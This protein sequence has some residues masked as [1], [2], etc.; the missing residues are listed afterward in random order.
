MSGNRE[1]L[2]FLITRYE[3]EP[4][5][6]RATGLDGWTQF[7]GTMAS[8]RWHARSELGDLEPRLLKIVLEELR[9]D[10]SDHQGRNNSIFW[11]PNNT[12]FWKEKS[13]EF[14]RVAEEV[15]KEKSKSLQT[16]VYVAGYFYNGLDLADRAITVLEDAFGRGLL[17]ENGWATLVSY[18]ESGGHWKK[19]VRYLE[20]L[21]EF[22]PDN[23]DYRMRLMVGYFWLK[24]S[25]KLVEA[26]DATDAR[27]HE[28]G[29]W[30]EGTLGTVA[31]TCHRVE[32]WKTGG[33][34]L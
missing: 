31:T 3:K 15:L 33:G 34:V 13:G 17:D 19:V 20:P 6:F 14:A 21:V 10:L 11:G 18:L 28:K 24:E 29:W 16:V 5:S 4:K 12:Y 23:L 27:W 1:G 26:L 22:R 8:Y 30:N 32:L 9:R 2:R 7:G 25:G